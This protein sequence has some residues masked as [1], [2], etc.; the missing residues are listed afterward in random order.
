M[1]DTKYRIGLS[2]SPYREDDRTEYIFALTGMPVG[3]D[4]QD[5]EPRAH[6][7]SANASSS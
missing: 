7:T 4:W 1:I 3:I 2:A 6:G 5:L